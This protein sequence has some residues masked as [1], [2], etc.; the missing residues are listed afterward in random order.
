[1]GQGQQ[2][3]LASIGEVHELFE[4]RQVWHLLF[5]GWA[6]D[7]H[8]GRITRAHGDVDLAV[9]MADL[10]PISQLLAVHGWKHV[11]S[12]DDDGGTG[13][14]R[15]AVRLELTFLE[16]DADGSM[17]IPLRAGRA[18]WLTDDGAAEVMDLD[19]TRCRVLPLTVLS[20]MKGSP[21]SDPEDAEKDRADY[22]VLTQVACSPDT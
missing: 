3:Q 6:V 10:G 22:H 7:F 2:L 15:N 13:F 19:G 5:G 11:P 17:F 4:A 16:P 1:M 8:V 21:R 9:K 18:T 12:E 14:V 20:A